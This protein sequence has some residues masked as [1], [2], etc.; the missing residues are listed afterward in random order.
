MSK[1]NT[2]QQSTESIIKTLR[3]FN[4]KADHLRSLTY[5]TQVADQQW[6]IKWDNSSRAASITDHRPHDESREA[7]LLTLRFFEN[8]L[9][10]KNVVAL[11]KDLPIPEEQK[12]R[13]FES[14]EV[15][16]EEMKIGS[17]IKV[18]VEGRTFTS[19]EIFKSFM[20]GQYCHPQ[21]PLIENLRLFA[22]D[23][24]GW[25]LFNHEFDHL[26][27]LHLKFIFWL[28]HMNAQTI[29]ALQEAHA[30]HAG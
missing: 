1:K 12:T 26:V 5:T 8:E 3:L 2:G 22:K 21:E 27:G 17:G 19:A 13:V 10:I 15:F 29:R 28:S 4:E 23:P 25:M 30:P 6:E 11:Y 16:E 24:L 14:L 7:L 20:Y 18:N 9:K